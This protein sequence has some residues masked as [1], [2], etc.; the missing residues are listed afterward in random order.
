MP[1]NRDVRSI[2]GVLRQFLDDGTKSVQ[3][4]ERALFEEGLTIVS[5]GQEQVLQSMADMDE[6]ELNYMVQSQMEIGEACLTE[7]LRRKSVD[8]N[9]T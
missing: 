6:D 1:K 4:L 9:D 2:C 8:N 7:L 3:W 5:I